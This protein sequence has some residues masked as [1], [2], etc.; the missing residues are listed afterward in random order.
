MAGLNPW[1]AMVHGPGADGCV[2]G[3]LQSEKY[4]TVQL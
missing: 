3:I 4:I 2:I 1:D